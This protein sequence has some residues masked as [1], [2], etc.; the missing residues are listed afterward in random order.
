M[1][2]LRGKPVTPE[3]FFPLS[4]YKLLIPQ[5]I[6]L[7]PFPLSCWRILLGINLRLKQGW[8]DS[9]WQTSRGS[10]QPIRQG[11]QAMYSI[12]SPAHTLPYPVHL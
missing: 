11:T 3:W 10:S 1:G 8:G 5:D 12:P 6:S 2:G 7:F 4:H 9:P